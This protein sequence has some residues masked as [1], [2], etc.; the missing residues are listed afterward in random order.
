MPVDAAEAA[1]LAVATLANV[2]AIPHP[3]FLAYQSLDVDRGGSLVWSELSLK[4]AESAQSLAETADRL[5]HTL[6]G[7]TG[8]ESL[9]FADDGDVHLRYGSVQVL[10]RVSGDTPSVRL[11]AQVLGK[12]RSSEAQLEHLN[13]LNAGVGG[14]PRAHARRPG[15]ARRHPSGGGCPSTRRTMFR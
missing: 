5:L 2:M 11:H 14:R 3:G 8:I 12:V 6:R 9:D 15:R 1:S 4:V 10:A 13:N 7:A